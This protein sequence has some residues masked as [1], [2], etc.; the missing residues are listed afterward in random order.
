MVTK[1]VQLAL[2]I[3]IHSDE[4]TD[5]QGKLYVLMYAILNKRLEHPQILVSAGGSGSHPSWLPRDD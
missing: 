4:S 2:R 5:T 3:L 1:T